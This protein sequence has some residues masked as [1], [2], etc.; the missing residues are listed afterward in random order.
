[1]T[2]EAALTKRYRLLAQGSEP[3]KVRAEL[4]RDIAGELTP[5]VR[6]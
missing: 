4:V 3:G 2:P 6:G 1:M 5:A